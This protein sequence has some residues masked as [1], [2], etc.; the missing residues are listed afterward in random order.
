[1]TMMSKFLFAGAGFAALAAAA[2]SAAQYG[3]AYPARL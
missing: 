1:M 3:Y 2:P